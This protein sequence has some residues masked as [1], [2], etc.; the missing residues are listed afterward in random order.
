MDEYRKYLADQAKPYFEHVMR[1]NG[2]IRRYQSS[3]DAI[4]DCVKAIDYSREKVTVPPYVDAIP[5]KVAE[6]EELD[7]H[8]LH[9]ID[10]MIYERK[11]AEEIIESLDDDRYRD[12]LTYRFLNALPWRTVADVKMHMEISWCT[13]LAKEAMAAAFFKI[14]REWR[15]PIPRAD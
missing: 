14:P 8:Y 3:R 4:A 2:A 9:V 5:D 6:L 13:R 12:V 11:R 15:K 1:L 7:D 10:E